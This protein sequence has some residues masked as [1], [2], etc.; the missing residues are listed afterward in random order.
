MATEAD[1][2]NDGALATLVAV[3]TFSMIGICAFVTALVRSEMSSETERKEQGAGQEV[4]NVRDAQRAKLAAPAAWSDRGKGLVSLPIDRAKELVLTDLAKDPNSATPPPPRP[5][6]AGANPAANVPE[7]G[8]EGVDGGASAADAGDGV[9]GSTGTEPAPGGPEKPAEKKVVAL[10]TP[11]PAP[12]KPAPAAP[13]PAAP[14][15]AAPA[16]VATP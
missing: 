6:D 14:A 16:S 10:P 13:A 7:A 1:K 3:G 5:Q 12:P 15:P 2:V 8:T 9:Q 11:A 4:R